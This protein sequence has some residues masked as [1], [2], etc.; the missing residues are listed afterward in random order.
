[1]R[2][3]GQFLRL[4]LKNKKE[5]ITKK[6][7][8]ISLLVSISLVLYYIEFQ[9]PGLDFVAPGIKLGLS[10]IIVL[11]TLEI[12]N[13]KMALTVLFL[14]VLLSS[15]FGAGL[16]SFL[17]S[18]SGGLLSLLIMTFLSN[19][20]SRPFSIVGISIAGSFA[21][22]VGQL[23]M[24]SLILRNFRIFYYLQIVS[25]LSLATG[26]FTGIV[27]KLIT[28]KKYVILKHYNL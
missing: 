24:A 23:L 20:K 5:N 18:I 17:Y 9:L 14:K 26:L 3:K 25:Y 15:F 19:F 12:F 27:S 6:L 8:S 2:N 11:V 7:T 21:F 13:F 28:D 10:N 4:E 22:N 1:M 16:S